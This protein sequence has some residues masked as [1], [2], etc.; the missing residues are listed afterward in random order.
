VVSVTQWASS[1]LAIE[2]SE[3]VDYHNGFQKTT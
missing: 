2:R 1:V 3:P